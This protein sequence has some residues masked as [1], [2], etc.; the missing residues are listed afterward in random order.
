MDFWQAQQISIESF[1][2]TETGFPV[3]EQRQIVEIH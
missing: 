3:D 1:F 2:Y